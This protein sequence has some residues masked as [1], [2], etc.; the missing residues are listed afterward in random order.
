MKTKIDLHETQVKVLEILLFKPKAKFGELNKDKLS[1]DQFSFHLRELLKS[2]LI[3]KDSEGLYGLTIEGREFCG[4]FDTKTMEYEKQAKTSVVVLAT[5]GN[6]VLVQQ[7]LKSPYYG[8][9][10]YVTGK[11]RFGEKIVEAAKRELL[12][13]TGLEG[14]FRLAGVEHKMDYDKNKILLDDKYFYVVEATELENELELE[15]KEGKNEWMTVEEIKALDKKF[16][17][18][19]ILLN[20]VKAKKVLIEENQFEVSGF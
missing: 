16:D 19:E 3:E 14:K 10:G 6:K 5:M 1:T 2:G 7:R 18:M 4:R 11:V 13:E 8:Y 15:T 20:I 9:F 17:D 12:E